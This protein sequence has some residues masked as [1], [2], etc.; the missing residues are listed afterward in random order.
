MCVFFVLASL[1]KMLSHSLDMIK[2]CWLVE[3][4]IFSSL[5]GSQVELCGDQMLNESCSEVFCPCS[6]LRFLARRFSSAVYGLF[7]F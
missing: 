5:G 2:A 3:R 7:Y 1:S 4:F 6:Y